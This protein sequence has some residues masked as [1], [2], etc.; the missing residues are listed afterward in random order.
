MSDPLRVAAAVEAPTD[1]VVLRAIMKNILGDTEFDLQI[2]QPERSVALGSQSSRTGVGWGGVYRWCRQSADEG[3]GS[4]SGSSVLSNYDVLVVH[5]DADVA[6]MSYADAGIRDAPSRDL[7]C[8]Q[9]CPPP[10]RTTNE[11]RTVILDW[12][13]ESL[14]PL[15]VVLCTPSK[16]MDAWV[17]AAVWPS[18]PMVIRRNWECHSDPGGQLRVMPSERRFRKSMQDYRAKQHEMTDAWPSVS[19]SL[20]EA[21]R[22]S[23]EFFVAVRQAWVRERSWMR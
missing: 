17:V 7:P 16:N 8:N 23:H 15:Q 18:N 19:R 6:D 1:A 10:D 13:G 12:L 5:V 22:F 11:L 14:C 9:P 3:G 2:L 20:T 4:V 21:A